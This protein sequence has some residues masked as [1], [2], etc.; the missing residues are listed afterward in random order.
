MMGE[1]TYLNKPAQRVD[2]LDKVLGKARFVGDIHLAGMLFTAVLRSPVP[3]AM[4]KKLD[5]SLALA[6][7][8]VKAVVTPDDFVNHGNFG[9][10]IN[11]AYVLAWKKVRHVG[12]PIAAVAA[13]SEEA[14]RAG[15]KAI[16][17]ELE[18]LPVVTDM[19]HALDEDAPLVP[20]E[21]PL[22]RGNLVNT[23]L[24]R[25]GDPDPILEKCDFVFEKDYH[26]AHQEHA[27]LET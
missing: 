15:L 16:Q 11:D 20:L 24:V 1:F 18:E 25:N 21:A 23:H 14:A 17:F 22:G 10:P 8:G 27:Y 3:H 2:G 13:E 5:V 6:V 19:Q 26:F 7:P 9:W 12:D 4:I